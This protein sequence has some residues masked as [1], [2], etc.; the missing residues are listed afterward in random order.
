MTIQNGIDFFTSP[1]EYIATPK[2]GFLVYSKEKEL[3]A[4]EIAAGKKP[5]GDFINV[6][7][8]KSDWKASR[9]EK[10]Q[11]AGNIDWV[12]LVMGD[13]DYPV[14]TVNGPPSRY[15]NY[16]NEW[17]YSDSRS[18]EIYQDGVCIAVSPDPVLGACLVDVTVEGVKKPYVLAVCT[19]EGK[20]VAYSQPKQFYASR[21]GL[22]ESKTKMK[23]RSG[24][25]QTTEYGIVGWTQAGEAQLAGYNSPNSPW[26][27][28]SD[29][30]SGRHQK[31]ITHT[32]DKGNGSRD[33][34]VL[35]VI[36]STTVV[37]DGAITVLFEDA[38]Y[39]GDGFKYVEEVKHKYHKITGTWADP[40]YVGH[41]NSPYHRYW[42]K[43]VSTNMKL[44]GGMVIAVDY[45]FKNKKWI[46]AI[47]RQGTIRNLTQNLVSVD[48]GDEANVYPGPPKGSMQGTYGLVFMGG[49]PEGWIFNWE[50]NPDLQELEI[51][52]PD[53]ACWLGSG[54][55]YSGIYLGDESMKVSAYGTDYATTWCAVQDKDGNDVPQW[56]RNHYELSGQQRAIT[57]GELQAGEDNLVLDDEPGYLYFIDHYMTYVHYMDIR[58]QILCGKSVLHEWEAGTGSVAGYHRR[59]KTEWVI[60]K[61]N[62]IIRHPYVDEQPGM[63]A[64]GEKAEP[65]RVFNSGNP[66]DENNGSNYDF[67]MMG[68]VA[69]DAVTATCTTSLVEFSD[70]ITRTNHS[71]LIE[72]DNEADDMQF[73]WIKFYHLY[74]TDEFRTW[75][76][77]GWHHAL[78]DPD[79]NPAT[80]GFAAT[81]D[82]D[83]ICWYKYDMDGEKLASFLGPVGGP[84]ED[85][86]T[87]NTGE[88]PFPIGVL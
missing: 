73:S 19:K 21:A 86:V 16:N 8:K 22:E 34:S 40:N 81:I 56:F 59:M 3:T 25:A 85:Y 27:F 24:D 15:W 87:F 61:K 88:E 29:G 39:V 5:K 63:K 58:H 4:E 54:T 45:D 79:N 12:G 65:E 55:S 76:M 37:K 67:G 57:G 23:L 9:V 69:W 33:D 2:H 41:A 44:A 74:H 43:Q 47:Y 64:F 75:R 82:G 31:V 17:D 38:D 11:L 28:A 51:N 46:K 49:A 68:D 66:P 20:V 6:V 80:S 70:Y 18:D 14:V 10:K 62:K 60:Q 13:K 32:Y 83:Y 26:F 35:V 72:E 84:V 77:K 53:G 42:W 71:G 48:R 52:Q 1:T 7:R 50:M 78:S 36:K 30:L